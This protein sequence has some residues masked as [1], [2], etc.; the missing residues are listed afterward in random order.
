MNTSAGTRR[1]ALLL[2]TTIL[3]VTTGSAV[4]LT[5]AYAQAAAEKVHEFNIQSKSVRQTLNDIGRISGVA[6]VFNET[7]SASK[8]AKS[9][10]GPMSASQAIA[11]ALAGT[12]LNW[13][14]TNANTVTIVDPSAT[15]SGVV[16]APDGTTVLNTITVVGQGSVTEGSGSY[17]TGEMSTATGLNLS[18]R[19][20]PQCGDKCTDTGR[21]YGHG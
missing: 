13:R 7:A 15:S 12:G 18:I 5:R 1:F 19:E 10:R 14:F 9:V 11:T 20:T 16:T 8:V 4:F 17:T 6:V 2:A 21:G 3:S